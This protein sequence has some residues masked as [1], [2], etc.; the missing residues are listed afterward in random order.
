[1]Q[2]KTGGHDSFSRMKREQL[3]E[4]L[5]PSV[6]EIVQ[7]EEMEEKM[8]LSCLRWIARGLEVQKAIRKVKTDKEIENNARGKW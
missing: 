4:L 7:K 6:V 1:M 3:M 8:T 5:A 2:L